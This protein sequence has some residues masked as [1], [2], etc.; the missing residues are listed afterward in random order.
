VKSFYFTIACVGFLTIGL[1]DAA[2]DELTQQR[3]VEA[4]AAAAAV[5][6]YHAQCR[7]DGSARRMDNLNKLFVSTRRIT[8]LAVK[9]DYFPE[10][11]YRQVEHRLEQEF[12]ELLREYGGCSGAKAAGL[13]TQLTARYDA[14]V[15]AVRALP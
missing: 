14:A 6:F 13:L 9:D 1:A 7:G 15:A 2:P 11:N 3:C 8:V 5:D 4:V 10:R 12:M